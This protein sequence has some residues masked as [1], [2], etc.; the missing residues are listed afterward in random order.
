[1][2]IR[3]FRRR[4]SRAR[5]EKME[6]MRRKGRLE[7]SADLL[8]RQLELKFGPVPAAYAARVRKADEPVLQRWSERLLMAVNLPAVFEGGADVAQP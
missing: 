5:K 3:Y 6:A 1:M 8:L 4:F 2:V 7:G